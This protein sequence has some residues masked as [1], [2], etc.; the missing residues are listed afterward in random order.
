MCQ[1]LR[2]HT[3]EGALVGYPNFPRV[4]ATGVGHYELTIESFLGL[5][6]SHTDSMELPAHISLTPCKRPPPI[7]NWCGVTDLGPLPQF[8]MVVKGHPSSRA[9]CWID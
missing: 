2:Q 6:F 8:R 5:A 9:P 7:T 4:N 1:A 3:A